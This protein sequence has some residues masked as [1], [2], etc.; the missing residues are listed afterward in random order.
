MLSN[1][2]WMCMSVRMSA[3]VR[4]SVCVQVRACVYGR[5]RNDR[6]QHQ[7]TN[8][9][10]SNLSESDWRESDWR[11]STILPPALPLDHQRLFQ[12]SLFRLARS[13]ALFRYSTW[14]STDRRLTVHSTFPCSQMEAVA[15]VAVQNNPHHD[16]HLSYC[17]LRN[18]CFF[19]W[20][21]QHQELRLIPHLRIAACIMPRP[22][23]CLGVYQ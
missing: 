8:W 14:H 2:L 17:L 7:T 21:D 15:V 9:K 1:S 10:Q 22:T 13:H 19:R 20:S 12:I 6:A 3:C 4:V 11:E 5:N 18:A 23:G 16:Q